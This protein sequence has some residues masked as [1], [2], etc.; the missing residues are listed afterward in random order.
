MSQ[1]AFLEKVPQYLAEIES[2][3][4]KKLTAERAGQLQ[5]SLSDVFARVSDVSY[6]YFSC[7]VPYYFPYALC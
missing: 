1:Q 6:Y 7:T 3:T 2:L 4:G 5:A